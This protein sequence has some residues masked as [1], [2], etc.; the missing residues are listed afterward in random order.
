MQRKRAAFIHSAELEWYSYPPD[1][2]FKTERAGKTYRIIRSFG[3]LDGDGCRQIPP[4]PASRK[5]LET[6]HTSEYLNV[7]QEAAYGRMDTIGLYM[8]LG[9]PDTPVF[10]DMYEY[11]LL[12]SGATL[13]G[14]KLL[15][16]GDY[17]LAFNPSGGYHHAGPS[18]ASG[19]CYIND[20]AIACLEFARQGRRVVFLDVDAHHCDGVQEVFFKRRDVMTISMHESGLNTQDYGHRRG[21]DNDEIISGKVFQEVRQP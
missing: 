11:A 10:R 3:L 20:V 14:V 16:S 17:F 21:Q 5:I 15:L 2:P 6:F 19:F 4:E 7:L 1:C 18:H 12:A 8:G 13:K 9:T